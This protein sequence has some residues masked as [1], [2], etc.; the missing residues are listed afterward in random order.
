MHNACAGGGGRPVAALGAPRSA[1]PGSAAARPCRPWSGCWPVVYLGG[2][3]RGSNSVGLHF[4]ALPTRGQRPDWCCELALD[5]KFQYLLR[6][7]LVMKE[8]SRHR[9]EK[10]RGMRS[11]Q[12]AAFPGASARKLPN[13]STQPEKLAVVVDLAA[14]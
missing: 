10:D 7:W 13:S 4:L 14:A 1:P 12:P 2:V 9:G 11:L 3:P 5:C 8:G 6:V